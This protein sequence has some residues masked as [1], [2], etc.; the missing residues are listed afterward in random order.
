[1][2]TIIHSIET[3]GGRKRYELAA[4]QK[5]DGRQYEICRM[6]K[7]SR[8]EFVPAGAAFKF[9]ENSADVIKT[10]VEKIGGAI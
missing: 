5:A 6:K 1:M 8:G 10:L 2:R 3:N 9:G 7:N 4:E